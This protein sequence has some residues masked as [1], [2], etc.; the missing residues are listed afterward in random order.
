MATCVQVRPKENGSR[1]AASESSESL[2]K[3]QKCNK[4]AFK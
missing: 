4:E 1:T 2:K 3:L